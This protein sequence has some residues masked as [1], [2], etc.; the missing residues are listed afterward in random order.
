MSEYF[1]ALQKV[2]TVIMWRRAGRQKLGFEYFLYLQ[3][4]IDAS[5]RIFRMIISMKATW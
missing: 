5:V 1:L 3:F 2:S 4:H